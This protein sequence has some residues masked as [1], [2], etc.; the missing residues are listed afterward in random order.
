MCG[1]FRFWHHA[2]KTIQRDL[3]KREHFYNLSLTLLFFNF[4]E[5]LQ[6]TLIQR[7]VDLSVAPHMC[8]NS[9]SLMAHLE[10]N[11]R[12]GRYILTDPL[13]FLYADIAGVLIA[14]LCF[15][16]LSPYLNKV[17]RIAHRIGRGSLHFDCRLGLSKKEGVTPV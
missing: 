2:A 6:N 7:Q 9:T 16:S 4:T 17:L 5:K 15:L 12:S 13:N 3:F 11:L 8:S 10:F 14:R 1:Y